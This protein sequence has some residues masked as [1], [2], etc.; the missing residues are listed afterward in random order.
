M[1]MHVYSYSDCQAEKQA[2]YKK[3]QEEDEEEKDLASDPDQRNKEG[4]RMHIGS[5]Y[6]GKNMLLYTY[7]P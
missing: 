7:M 3:K 1:S 5:R 2:D 6:D 4:R